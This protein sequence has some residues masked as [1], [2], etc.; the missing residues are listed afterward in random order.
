MKPYASFTALVVTERQVRDNFRQ[1][2]GQHRLATVVHV[3]LL[4][5]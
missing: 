3:V 2:L 4:D 5:R 1:A